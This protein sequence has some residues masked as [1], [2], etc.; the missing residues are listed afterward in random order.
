MDL[1]ISLRPRI[2]ASGKRGS[3]VQRY[4]RQNRIPRG[5]L[6]TP[7]FSGAVISRDDG[8]LKGTNL[9]PRLAVKV[10]SRVRK[11][12]CGAT[13]NRSEVNPHSTPK[14]RPCLI[15]KGSRGK[16]ATQP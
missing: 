15:W 10:D 12:I 7:A 3:G 9:A 14:T 1:E 6:Q 11:W 8:S 4:Q 2:Y 5:S 13:A 16:R